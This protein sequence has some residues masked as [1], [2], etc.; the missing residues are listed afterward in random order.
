MKAADA[1]KRREELRALA[2]Q[3]YRGM[4]PGIFYSGRALWPDLPAASI[5]YCVRWLLAW[6]VIE[7]R[8]SSSKAR[9]WEYRRV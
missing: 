5:A 7:R 2:L 8:M 6:G 9:V 4:E 3:A 1:R